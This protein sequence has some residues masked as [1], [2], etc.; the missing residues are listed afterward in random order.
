[1]NSIFLRQSPFLFFVRLLLMVKAFYSLNYRS[2]VPFSNLTP[3][4]PPTLSCLLFQDASLVAGVMLHGEFTVG[5]FAETQPLNPSSH[6]HL[7]NLI[8]RNLKVSP[9][10]IGALVKKTAAAGDDSSATPPNG[11]NNNNNLNPYASQTVVHDPVGAV[12]DVDLATNSSSTG[13]YVSNPLAELQLAFADYANKCTSLG[14]SGCSTMADSEQAELLRRNTIGEAV[15]EWAL[16]TPHGNS[17]SMTLLKSVHK[18]E[19]VG[20]HDVMFHTAKGV[21]GL[22]LDGVSDVIV[23]NVVISNLQ[24][25]ASTSSTSSTSSTGQPGVSS[26]S[27]SS[28]R[29]WLAMEEDPQYQYTGFANRGLSIASSVKVEVD[30]ISVRDAVVAAKGVVAVGVET[31]FEVQDV[32]M[33][34]VQEKFDF[35]SE[36]T[37]MYTAAAAAEDDEDDDDGKKKKKKG[38]KYVFFTKDAIFLMGSTAI[39]TLLFT[40]PLMFVLVS[41][42]LMP[43]P[44]V[45]AEEVRP[46]PKR[47][48][49]S[50]P[51]TAFVPPAAAAAPAT[52]SPGK[53]TLRRRNSTKLNAYPDSTPPIENVQPLP[54][55]RRQTSTNSSQVR[56]PSP[57]Q[58]PPPAAASVYA[59]PPPFDVSDGPHEPL[60]PPPPPPPRP[61]YVAPQAADIGGIRSSHWANNG[62]HPSRKP[63]PPQNLKKGKPP[64]MRR[65]GGLGEASEEI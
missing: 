36:S 16:S 52:D 5:G 17:S 43:R 28:S 38:K 53:T 3:P 46:P 56:Q 33:K 31:M 41:C 35:F 37:T 62:G 58:P 48:D 40:F 12:F 50:N 42:C 61:S 55:P 49:S 25:L 60:P 8:I 6:I 57:R 15:V 22:K 26:S 65:N 54:S 29:S 30:K 39:C 63:P 18:Y 51:N 11:N 44:A 13:A 21:V 47:Q 34:N 2:R 9:S 19:V 20:N 23:E 1:L 7:K 14:A 4:Q 32:S 59:P 27:S 45:Q 64:H 10:E 24:N